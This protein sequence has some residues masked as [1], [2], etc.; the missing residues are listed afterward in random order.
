MYLKVLLETGLPGLIG[1]V[2]IIGATMRAALLLVINTRRTELYPV[3]VALTASTIG[4]C[5]FAFFGPILY[6]R[7]YWLPMALTWCLW[8]IRREELR[9]G[10]EVEPAF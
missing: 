3:A 1:L 10:H 5:T 6:H 2:V 9:A 4:G 7:F 8:A